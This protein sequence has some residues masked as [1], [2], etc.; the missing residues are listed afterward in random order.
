MNEK[1]LNSKF[2]WTKM[3][4]KFVVHVQFVRLLASCNIKDDKKL[5]KISCHLLSINNQSSTCQR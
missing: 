2:A 4:G 3:K 5:Q 1:T